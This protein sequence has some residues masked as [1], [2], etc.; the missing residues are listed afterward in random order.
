M[1]SEKIKKQI[2]DFADKFNCPILFPDEIQKGEHD[3]ILKW[4]DGKTWSYT[5]HVDPE[6]RDGTIRLN[7]KLKNTILN[8]PQ[9]YTT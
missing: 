4:S 8:T 3:I 1:L 7:T 9:S 2:I 5:F 6:I